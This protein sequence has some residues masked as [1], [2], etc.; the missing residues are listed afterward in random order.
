M[1]NAGKHT[2]YRCKDVPSL[3]AWPLILLETMGMLPG[4]W[5]PRNDRGE[6]PK[7]ESTLVGRMEDYRCLARKRMT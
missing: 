2:G 1:Q 5:C 3:R 6:S 7:M 4:I